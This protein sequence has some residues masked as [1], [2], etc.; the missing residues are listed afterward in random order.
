[1]VP[2]ILFKFCLSVALLSWLWWFH[3][4]PASFKPPD[5]RFSSIALTTTKHTISWPM[6]SVHHFIFGFFLLIF[7]LFEDREICF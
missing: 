7:N 3:T 5:Y 6:N 1:V 4:L 2:L